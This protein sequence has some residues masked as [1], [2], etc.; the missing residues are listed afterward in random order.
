MPPEVTTGRAVVFVGAVVVVVCG[1]DVVVGVELGADSPEDALAGTVVVGTVAVGKD[2][3]DGVTFGSAVVGELIPGCS[4][5]TTTPIR[6]LA[7]VAMSD[8]DLVKRRRRESARCLARGE[9][10]GCVELMALACTF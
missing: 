2:V 3:D 4:L 5:A 6:T 10:F 9:P 1:S 8:A 7:P